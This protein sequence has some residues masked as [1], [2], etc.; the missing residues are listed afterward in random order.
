[1]RGVEVELGEGGGQVEDWGGGPGWSG[2]GA[3]RC[4]NPKLRLRRTRRRRL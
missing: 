4:P 3:E 1:M 2:R